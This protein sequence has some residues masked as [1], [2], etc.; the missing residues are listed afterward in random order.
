M[1]ALFHVRYFIVANEKDNKSVI[2]LHFI[3]N[4]TLDWCQGDKNS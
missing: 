4:G 3:H 1:N 2:L